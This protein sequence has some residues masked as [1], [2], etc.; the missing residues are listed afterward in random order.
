MEERKKRLEGRRKQ[1]KEERRNAYY[2]QKEEEAQ[3]I[4]EEQLKKGNTAFLH[5]CG[6]T[7]TSQITNFRWK[8]WTF[9]EHVSCLSTNPQVFVFSIPQNVKKKRK[10]P[11]KGLV[12]NVADYGL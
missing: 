7:E 1:R 10:T 12:V 11:L 5:V 6:G 9:V 2:R 8:T 4:R 3:R